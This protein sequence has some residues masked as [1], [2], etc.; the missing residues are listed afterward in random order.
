MIKTG[1]HVDFNKDGTTRDVSDMVMKAVP[2]DYDL[3]S[4]I[5]LYPKGSVF[6]VPCGHCSECRLAYRKEWAV[7]C[8]A[9]A[10]SHPINCFITLTM[11]DAHYKKLDRQDFSDFIKALRNDGHKV[12]FFACAE[13]GS[14][15]KRN[16]YHACLF[17]YMPTD[18]TY[19]GKSDSGELMYR[20]KYLE[21]K[22]QKGFVIVQ[23][24]SNKTAGYVAGYVS[25]KYGA[26]DGFLMM[27][28]HPGLGFDYYQK[29]KN[30][31]KDFDKLYVN[32]STNGSCVPRYFI[33][34]LEKDGFDVSELKEARKKKSV[35]S[36]YERTRLHGF[37]YIEQSMKYDAFFGDA[38]L[39][40]LRRNY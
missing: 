2:I 16:H 5:R 23:D 19:H 26:E 13:K 14:L 20:S 31:I 35:A 10:E 18:L 8:V 3:S 22:W 21:D 15:T 38:K 4:F 40:R 17:G 30:C 11:D 9:E 6:L 32:I 25:K 37:E 24:F 33:K 39:G 1:S 36:L 7:R 28:T 29:H 12:R 34:L 27:S